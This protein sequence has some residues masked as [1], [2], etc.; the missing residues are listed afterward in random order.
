MYEV[1]EETENVHDLINITIGKNNGEHKITAVH[2]T[3]SDANENMG[4][5]MSN[6]T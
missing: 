6:R 3:I 2:S 1:T 4:T 5:L